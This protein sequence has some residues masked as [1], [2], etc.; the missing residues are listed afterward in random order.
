MVEPSTKKEVQKLIGRITALNR[1]ILKSIEHN[2]PFFEALRGRD[3]VEWG[4]EL[5]SPWLLK[6][7]MQTNLAFHQIW[8]RGIL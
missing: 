7:F 4:P 3:K 1:F 2:L 5:T 6:I 8:Q